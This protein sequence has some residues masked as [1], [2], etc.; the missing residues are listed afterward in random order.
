MVARGRGRSIRGSRLS[1]RSRPTGCSTFSPSS[2]RRKRCAWTRAPAP[3]GSPSAPQPSALAQR[4]PRLERTR[5]GSRR[6]GPARH[7]RPQEA[8]SAM[9]M[10][11]G[12]AEHHLGLLT[13]RRTQSVA[14]GGRKGHPGGS[15]RLLRRVRRRPDG[16]RRMQERLAE[17]RT[18]TAR[19]RSR[20]RRPGPHR[21]TPRAASTPPAGVRRAGRVHVRPDRAVDVPLSAV[22]SDLRRARQATQAASLRCSRSPTAWATSL[23]GSAGRDDTG[24][25]V[26]HRE[27]ASHRRA[28][29]LT[30]ARRAA[31]ADHARQPPA[32][33]E[34]RSGGSAARST[35]TGLRFRVDIPDRVAWQTRHPPGRCVHAGP[36]RRFSSTG[37]SGTD[38]PSTGHRR[39]RNPALLVGED[40]DQPGPGPP[41]DQARSRRGWMDS[42]CASGSTRIPRRG[43]DRRE[44]S[45]LEAQ[46]SQRAAARASA[47]AEARTR[48]PRRGAAV[49][50]CRSGG[51]GQPGALRSGSRAGRSAAPRP[52]GR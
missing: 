5:S 15:P 48:Q 51:T 21:A 13:R 40:R 32:R 25:T 26:G 7:R 14:A 50:R 47:P 3:T 37:A 41:A 10:R 44:C 43:G 8:D 9:A 22:R 27:A 6:F 30:P 16:D 46:A 11:G 33:L 52:P 39:G 49:R 4:R 18:Q 17:A 45:A 38:V 19:R 20:S 42:R 2:G 1:S 24:L 31:R 35:R 28:R 12:V 29:R 34:A 23:D 36:R